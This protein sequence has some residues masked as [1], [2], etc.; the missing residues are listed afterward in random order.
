ME[1]GERWGGGGRERAAAYGSTEALAYAN[2][3]IE[4]EPI[5]G[6][7]SAGQYAGESAG[8]SHLSSLRQ[9]KIQH[10]VHAAAHEDAEV[11]AVVQACDAAA[12]AD[13]RP[14]EVAAIE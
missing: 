6:L 2:L 1:G 13:Q 10:V 8:E 11:R 9:P 7:C 5:F 14:Q 3:R 12:V 4:S